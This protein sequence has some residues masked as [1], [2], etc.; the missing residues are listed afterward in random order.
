M[1]TIRTDLAQEAHQLWR[2]SAGK[3]TQLRGVRATDD[4]CMGF[5]LHR[6]EIL[7]EAGEKALNKPCGIYLT[8]DISTIW[9]ANVD[10]PARA[11][12]ALAALLRPLLP[13]EG[14]VLVAGLGNAAMTPDALGPQTVGQLLVTRH[15]GAILP[16]LRPVAALAA[17][18]LGETGVEAAEWVRG[19]CGRVQPAAVVLVDALAARELGRLCSTVQLSD[20]G[21]VPGSGV[22]NHR[23]ALNRDTLGVPVLSIGV[24]TVV[25]IDT[26]AR[27][28]L[29]G[30]GQG[31][32]R[33]RCLPDQGKRLFVT[34]D[35]IDSQIR[36]LGRLLGRGISLA[37][38]PGLTA[39]EVEGLLEG[40]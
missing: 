35:R 37:A 17:G 13:E 39:E 3:K 34:P 2:E 27:D 40:Q 6:V 15:L 30:A 23:M 22:G 21:L 36:T 26:I 9:Q 32:E 10:I 25:D 20:T 28:I 1:L 4:Q 16:A 31:R 33:P 29:T 7:D 14:T 5:P 38:Q 24:P 19:V 8:L 18:V 11:S 12:Q